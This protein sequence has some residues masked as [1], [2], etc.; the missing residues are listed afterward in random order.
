[1]PSNEELAELSR[2]RERQLELWEQIKRYAMKTANQWLRAF[3]L[4]C[5]VEFDDLMSA[6]YIAMCEAASTYKAERGAFTTVV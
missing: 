5:D 2:D 3:P 4:R 6:A 1:M